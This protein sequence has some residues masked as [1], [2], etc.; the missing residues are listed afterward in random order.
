[1]RLNNLKY[2]IISPEKWIRGTKVTFHLYKM[3]IWE[4]PI[5]RR[6]KVVWLDYFK[7]HSSGTQSSLIWLLLILRS[8]K[9]ISGWKKKQKNKPEHIA[10]VH[11]RCLI[12]FLLFSTQYHTVSIVLSEYY[13]TYNFI[14]QL[15]LLFLSYIHILFIVNF[16]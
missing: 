1:M 11:L 4:S 10:Y 8:V 7:R 16:R 15:G 12:E 14:Y 2:F 3:N 9:S 13:Y 5:L 6:L